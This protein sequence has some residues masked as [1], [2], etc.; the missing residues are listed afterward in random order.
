M[1]GCEIARCGGVCCGGVEVSER[2]WESSCSDATDARK[3][4]AIN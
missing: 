1:S 2:A 3:R 4:D